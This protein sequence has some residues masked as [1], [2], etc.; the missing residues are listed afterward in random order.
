MMFYDY[1]YVSPP[2]TLAHLVNRGE[3]SELNIKKTIQKIIDTAHNLNKKV[4]VVSDA[5][6]LDP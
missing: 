6:Y 3:I 5:Y 4:I 2:K 1:I